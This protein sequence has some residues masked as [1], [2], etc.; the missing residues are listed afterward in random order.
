M[1]RLHKNAPK[2]YDLENEIYFIVSKTENNYQFFKEP[3]FCELFIE[4][5]KL[6]KELK[7]FRLYGFSIIY[8]HVNLLIQPSK[9]FGISE[10]MRSLK[11]NFSRDCNYIM[12]F[13]KIINVGEVA[14]P[15]LRNLVNN[16]IPKLKIQFH[17]KYSKNHFPK[18]CWQQSYYDHI[19]RNEADLQNHFTYA[20]YNYLKHGLPK[21]WKYTSINYLDLI[22]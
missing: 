3:I 11:T 18:F 20:V 15:R 12:G 6:C 10:I 17:K 9:E 2:R 1:I 8:D 14:P 19:C 21:D 22:N 7:Q 13:N 4:E 5:L 16:F